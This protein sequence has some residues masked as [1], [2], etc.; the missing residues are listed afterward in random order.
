MIASIAVICSVLIFGLVYVAPGLQNTA[1]DAKSA[2]VVPDD[3]PSISD[4][5]GTPPKAPQYS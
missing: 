3:Y 1:P 2:L 4:A 5:V